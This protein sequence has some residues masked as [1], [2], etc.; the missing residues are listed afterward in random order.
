MTN[1]HEDRARC[2]RCNNSATCIGRYESDGPLEFGCDDCC[3]HGNEDGF[4]WHHDEPEFRA[5]A[6]ALRALERD[7]VTKAVGWVTHYYGDM[8]GESLR[9]ELEG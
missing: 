1:R 9:R 8:P 2:S 4:C 6:A 5:I 7:M 3:G